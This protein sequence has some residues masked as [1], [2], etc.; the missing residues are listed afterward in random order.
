MKK[1]SV[2]FYAH[3]SVTRIIE[4]EVP[5]GASQDE[6]TKLATTEMA[7]QED[8]AGAYNTWKVNLVDADSILL[9]S[10]GA[11]KVASTAPDVNN[12]FRMTPE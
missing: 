5:D 9:D 11:T 7:H 10:M 2:A 12:A 1:V 4:V 3:A 6:A 8:L